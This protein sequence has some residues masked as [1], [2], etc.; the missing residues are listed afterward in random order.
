LK[1]PADQLTEPEKAFMKHHKEVLNELGYTTDFL[2]K[3]AE[4]KTD[5]NGHRTEVYKERFLLG[6]SGHPLQKFEKTTD[7]DGKII[8]MEKSLPN[9]S[10]HKYTEFYNQDQKVTH[11]E[12]QLA[13]FYDL[14]MPGDLPEDKEVVIQMRTMYAMSEK[15]TELRDKS[16][17]IIAK[18]ENGKFFDA[19]GKEISEDNIRKMINKNKANKIV[20]YNKETSVT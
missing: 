6:V 11:N 2:D 17:N 8:S 10:K 5:K 13:Q 7:K 14:H 9:S 12:I 19:K 18:Y 3:S 20:F 4:V 1:K 16:G 15:P